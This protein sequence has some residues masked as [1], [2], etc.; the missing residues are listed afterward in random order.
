MRLEID[1]Q[2][3]RATRDL[4]GNDLVAAVRVAVARTTA[5]N[6]AQPRNVIRWGP[7]NHIVAIPA[8]DRS[9]LAGYLAKYTTKSVDTGGVLDRRL[10]SGELDGLPVAEH[11]RRLAETAWTLAD[12]PRLVDLN[13]RNW[14]HT[15]GYRGHW[16]TKSR[17]WST[18]LTQLRT[19]RHNWQLAHHGH[20]P[21][22]DSTTAIG[23]WAYQGNGHTTAAD[24]WLA[25]HAAANR[26]QHRRI[27]WE[28]R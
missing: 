27:A 18:T 26:Q 12:H 2:G 22:T 5:P 1:P 19:D 14:A 11:L 4:D 16:L 28:E 15:L 25:R 8:G 23:E 17:T 7:Q 20:H 10:R 3:S 21:E 13:L 24:A 9:R 6:P